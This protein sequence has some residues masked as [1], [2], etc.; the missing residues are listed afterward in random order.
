MFM[1]P[2][3][4][5]LGPDIV[6]LAAGR[7]RRLGVD[8][9]KALLPLHN[10]SGTLTLLLEAL[11]RL[12][13]GRIH[14]VTGHAADAVASAARAVVPDVRCV[15]NPDP[16]GTEMLQSLAIALDGRPSPARDV[17]VLS[18]DTLYAPGVLAGLLDVPAGQIA[19][20]VAPSDALT[21]GEVGVIV[22]G[23]R[24]HRLGRDLPGATFRMAHAVR[25]PVCWQHRVTGG[26]REGQRFQWEVLHALLTRPGDIAAPDIRAVK[27][28]AGAA[29]DLD[30]PA[31]L[32]ALRRAFASS[33]PS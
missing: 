16:A 21:R 2:P 19:I 25:W 33:P 17:W 27:I 15:H 10:G 14:L 28:A 30:T 4:T 8:G 13:V 11:A 22:E 7:G 31:D 20:T 6:L 32:I 29:T 12:P 26:A 3:D 23:D 24:V 5:P 9:H 1:C 18:A